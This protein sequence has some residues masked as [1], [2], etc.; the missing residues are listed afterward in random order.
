MDVYTA[1][2]QSNGSIDK[3]KS[4]IMVRGDLLNKETVGDTWS[5]TSS[6]R[7]LKYFLADAAKYK[8]RVH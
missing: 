1:K 3:V 5:P 4:R 7:T 8:T 2:I 6:M